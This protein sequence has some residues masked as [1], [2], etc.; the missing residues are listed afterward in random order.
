MK[1][2]NI[3]GFFGNFNDLKKENWKE[4][5][6]GMPEFIQEDQEPFKTISVHFEKQ[7]DVDAFAKLVDQKI[8]TKT[9]FIWYPKVNIVECM[10]KEYIDIKKRGR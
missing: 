8:N 10:N 7:E 6:Q 1:R 4:E 3:K 9:H 5:W 2:K